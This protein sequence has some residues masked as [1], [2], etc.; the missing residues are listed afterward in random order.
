[1]RKYFQID[2]SQYYTLAAVNDVPWLIMMTLLPAFFMFEFSFPRKR[3]PVLVIFGIAVPAVLLP[4]LVIAGLIPSSWLETLHKIN[5]VHIYATIVFSSAI[6][7]RAIRKRHAGGVA[8][9]LGCCT[10]LA[11]VSLSYGSGAENAWAVGFALLIVFLTVSLSRQMAQSSRQLQEV[12]LRSARLE[13]ELLKKHIQ[14]H[15]L[16]NSL[17]S[18]VA[19]LEE[20]PATAAKLVTALADELRM[21]M[22]FASRPLV[23]LWEEVRL[24]RTHVEVMGLRHLKKFTFETRTVSSDL[25]VPPLIIHTMLENALTHGYARRDSGTFI[26]TCE[27]KADRVTLTLFNDGR[28]A[29]G[30]QPRTEGTGLKY[31]RTRLEEQFPGRWEVRY[32]PVQDGWSI[33]VDLWQPEKP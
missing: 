27:Q 18:I 8:A 11:G 14:P 10:F 7:V 2:L 21:L 25:Q 29:G 12:E 5:E 16:L 26:L 28:T 4:R 30:A 31:I 19:W 17:N 3:I 9:L 33:S 23:S 13:I 6:C 32:G 24:C 15:F 1:M 20:E 22:T